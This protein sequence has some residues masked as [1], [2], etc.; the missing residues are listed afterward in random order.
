V[1]T[2]VSLRDLPD[3]AERIL[4]GGVR[5]RTVVAVRGSE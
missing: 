4:A 5:G 3:L 1:T 2:E